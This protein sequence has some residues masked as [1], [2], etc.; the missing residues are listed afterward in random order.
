MLVIR[1]M[2]PA[3]V[4]RPNMRPCSS[5]CILIAFRVKYAARSI[6]LLCHRR[7]RQRVEVVLGG[8]AC[9]STAQRNQLCA[10]RSHTASPS[11]SFRAVRFRTAMLIIERRRNPGSLARGLLF[12]PRTPGTPEHPVSGAT[13]LFAGRNVIVHSSQR[14]ASPG[15]GPCDGPAS[16]LSSTHGRSTFTSTT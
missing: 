16:S 14:A 4:F 12:L 3:R 8:R 2:T 5:I 9:N 11:P 1:L 6:S 13:L 10:K 15:D 7:I